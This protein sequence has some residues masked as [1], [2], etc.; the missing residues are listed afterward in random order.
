KIVGGAVPRTYIPSVEK[1]VV[2][3]LREGV[4]AHYPLS[5]LRVTLFDGKD[6]PVDSSDI[7]FKIAGSMALKKG[8]TDAQPVLLEPIMTMTVTV[9][10]AF[11]GDIMGDL[12]AKRARVMGMSPAGSGFTTIEAQA[13]LAEV[14]RYAADLRSLTQGRGRYSMTLDHYEEV[15]QH[16]AQR[17]IDQAQKEREAAQKG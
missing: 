13:P 10:D 2:E 3:A 17:V 5:D 7:A 14:Q 12:N 8:A 1:G 11:T 6:H 16:A 4:L 15:P 9:P